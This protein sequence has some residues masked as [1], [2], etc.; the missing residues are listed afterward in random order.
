MAAL[1]GK[2][3]PA[4]IV[5]AVVAWCCWPYLNPVKPL[6]G[7]QGSDDLPSVADLLLQ[8]AIVSA[9]GRDP[10]QP[11]HVPEPTTARVDL[12]SIE[13]PTTP[14]PL[15]E[16]PVDILGSLRL[17]ATFIHGDRRLALIN[18][19]ICARGES[20]PVLGA[21]VDPCTIARISA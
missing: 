18:G 7:G 21:A 11:L 5:A 19:R 4:A 9:S 6:A 12:V 20:L 14:D 1:I 15:P 8:P 2:L 3:A 10:F 13:E 16:E 17:D